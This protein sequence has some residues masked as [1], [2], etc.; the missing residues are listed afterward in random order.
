MKKE[1]FLR[2]RAFLSVIKGVNMCSVA[3]VGFDPEKLQPTTRCPP[4]FFL[5]SGRAPKKPLKS[6]R[7]NL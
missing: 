3:T 1:G 7:W 6:G 2:C 5:N 4:I